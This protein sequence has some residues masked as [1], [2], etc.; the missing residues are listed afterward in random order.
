MESMKSAMI[1]LWYGLRHSF[2]NPAFN[3][4]FVAVILQSGHT[5]EHF[6]QMYQHLILGLPASQSHGILGAADI[7]P[8]HFWWNISI[9][10]SLI[11][12]YYAWEFNRPEGTLQQFVD[13]RRLMNMLLWVQGYHTAEHAL[14]YYQHIATGRQGTPGFIGNFIGPNLIFFHF[15]INLIVYPGMVLLLVLY[16]WHMQLYPA[17]LE[18]RLRIRM[19]SLIKLAQADGL[20]SDDER[21]LLVRMRTN[22]DLFARELL[23]RLQAGADSQQVRERLEEMQVAMVDMLVAQAMV[24]GKI[25][26]EEQALID[27]FRRDNPI[28]DVLHKLQELEQ[29][30]H[31]PEPVKQRPVARAFSA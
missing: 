14:K 11:V 25:T 24:D 8:V 15:F 21:L 4:L 20:L 29:I 1:R 30:D 5:L 16:I 13:L 19:R 3:V 18:A 23:E 22:V 27:A 7:E 9:M 17:Y 31:V 12:I 10:L 28:A 2:G 26:A 6:A